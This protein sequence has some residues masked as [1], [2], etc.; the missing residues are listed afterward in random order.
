MTRVSV[1]LAGDCMMTR[2]SPVTADPRSLALRDLLVGADFAVANLEVVPSDGAGHP[3]G[4]AAGGGC[5]IADSGVL[6]EIR[7]LGFTVLGCANNHALD[8][9][10]GGLLDTMK[11]LRERRM[12]F[13]GVGRTLAEARAPAYADGPT[14]SLALISCASTFAAGQEAC[15]PSGRLPGRPGLNPLR[16]RLEVRVTLSQLRALTEIDDQTGLRARRAEAELL[17]G[18]D[19]VRAVPGRLF[20]FGTRFQVGERAGLRTQCEA[21]DLA[22]VAQSVSD[23]RQR[24]DVVVVTVHSHEPGPSDAD[25]GEFLRDFAHR[26]IESGA[27]AVACH[28]PHFLKAVEFYRGRPVFFSLG[29]IVSQ[30]E[31]GEL[32]PAEDYATV[33][34]PDR[35]SPARYFAARCKD[36]TVL[37]APHR[38]YWESVLP[39][40]TF[41]NGELISA[42]LHPV[43]LGFGEPVHRRGRP[44]L[45]DA[46]L[47]ADIL[48]RLARMSAPYGS[49]VDVDKHGAGVVGVISGGNSPRPG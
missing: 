30:I 10:T 20:L 25:P 12:T 17:L 9:G 13:A 2:G 22:A 16:Y 6:D 24:A 37:F 41:D 45:A 46:N 14:G 18:V 7:A 40:L 47:G 42:V 43:D 3:A 44:R 8:M 15:E 11:L 4:S 27:D 33:P 34:P 26:M 36:G 32:I 21:P 28:G 38:R 35:V 23:A 29:N 31:L 5:L 1:A 39:V 48:R 19:P 49:R